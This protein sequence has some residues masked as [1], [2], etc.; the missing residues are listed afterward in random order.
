LRWKNRDR[1]VG[2]SSKAMSAV[3]ATRVCPIGFRHQAAIRV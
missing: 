1:I 2:T 3:L